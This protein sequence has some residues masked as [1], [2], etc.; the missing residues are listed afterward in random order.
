MLISASNPVRS[1]RDRVAGVRAA[2]RQ[3][4]ARPRS[5]SR[6]AAAAGRTGRA[7]APGS[8]L[9]HRHVRSSQLDDDRRVVGGQL[10]LALLAVDRRRRSPGRPAPGWP[11]RSRSACRAASGSSAGCSPSRCRRPGPG[12]SGRTTSVKPASTTSSN[13]CRSGGGDVRGVPVVVDAPDVVVGGRDVEV[14]AER[15][16]RVRVGRP[17][18]SRRSRAAPPATPACSRS[19]GRRPPGR[20]ARTGSTPGRP[21]QTAPIDLASVTAGSPQAGS[22]GTPTWTSSSPT[23]E[24]TATPFH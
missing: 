21:P 13:A 12:C 18:A 11:G 17:V 1:C 14:A 10:A 8:G 7:R 15:D 6:P 22:P 23:R 20:S 5:A 3:L 16:L 2:D 9:G 24:S 4:G 19:A